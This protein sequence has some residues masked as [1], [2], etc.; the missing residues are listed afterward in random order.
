MRGF[1]SKT[2]AI[3][4]LWLA[5]AAP[6]LADVG[7]FLAEVVAAHGGGKAP[8]AIHERGTT[9]SLRRGKG[10]LERW[11]Q[12]PDRFRI[13]IAYPAG[14]ES[15]LLRGNEA[16]QR[17]VPATAAIHGA[18]MLQEAHMAL[19]WR[20]QENARQVI[21][22]GAGKTVD[23]KPLRVLEWPV[24]EGIK[25]I[26]EIDPA[27]RLILRSRGILTI[28]D[29]SMEFVTGYENYQTMAGRRVAMIERHFAMGH[30]IGTTVLASVEF[31]AVLPAP[32][33]DPALAAPVLTQAMAR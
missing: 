12:A 8:T 10:P 31:P 18:L 20:L 14:A 11:W 30:Y 16:W 21:D 19:P 6:A 25:L 3:C 13:E 1:A 29:A 27:T 4:L 9:Q 23:G 26:V 7:E 32:T 5:L 33:F 24:R 2:M 15:R 28:G 17:G 22:L